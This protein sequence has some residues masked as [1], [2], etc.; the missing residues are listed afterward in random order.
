MS[1]IERF[2]QAM[3][4]AGLATDADIVGD[5]TL[6][7]FHVDGDRSGSKNGWLVLHLDGVAAGAFGSWK[8]GEQHTWCAKASS[9]LT[10]DERIEHRARIDA[11][12]QAR[13]DEERRVKVAAGEEARRQWKAAATDVGE[14]PYLARKNVQAHGLRA[15]A[16]DL[17]VPVHGSDGTLSSI[18]RIR[19]D[20]TKRFLPGGAVAG[21]Y[22]AI[23]R[24]TDRVVVC[25]GYATGA[26]IHEACGH[27]VAVAFNAGNLEPVARAIRAK[28]PGVAILIAADDDAATAQNPGRTK[29]TAAALAA[30][31]VVA[32]PDFGRSRPDAVSDFNDLAGL[33]GLAAVAAQ[34]DLAWMQTPQTHIDKV[35]L[36]RARDI[37][38]QRIE[39]LW[40]GFLAVSM[41]HILAGRAGTG[42][43]TI[44]ESFAAIR[45]AGGV[46]PDG[47]RAE[48]GA[49][50]IWSGEDQVAETL[51]PRLMAMGADLDLIYFIDAVDEAEGRRSFDPAK[52][53]EMLE[54][55][56]ARID[57]VKLLIVDPIVSAVR[58]S[59]GENG[60][61][62]RDLQP[63]VDLGARRKIAILGIT[64]FSKGTSGRDALERVTGSLAYGALA[65]IVLGTG[66]AA[67]E[68]EPN[69]LARIKSNIGP[70]GGGYEYTISFSEI[71]PGII[72]SRV[73]WG[74][75]LEGSANDIFATC[76]SDD[77]ATERDDAAWWLRTEL[78]D[79]PI[80]TKDLQRLARDAGHSWP[81][82]K[83][84]KKDLGV[85]SEKA[86]FQGGWRWMLPE[87]DQTVERDPLG[88][89]GTPKASPRKAFTEGDQGP[90]EYDPLR[91]QEDHNYPSVIPFG[92][93]RTAAVDEAPPETEADHDHGDEPLRSLFAEVINR[94]GRD[95]GD[96]LPA[97]MEYLADW[98]RDDLAELVSNP[99]L[100]DTVFTTNFCQ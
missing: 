52:D 44:A 14:H 36:L 88:G 19:P 80:A 100:A 94:H 12:K 49:V 62:R 99:V 43:T 64:H 69:T 53:M 47:S 15:D 71:E 85:I 78:A 66:K 3:A 18:Q 61:T 55:E 50:V 48:K 31:G 70:D 76:E 90:L 89:T 59:S 40:S 84:A 39:W 81:T 24:V 7:R 17:L 63:L 22:H 5:G 32:V 96:T 57:D 92:E 34:I 45:S 82:V 54:R 6:Q 42:K 68:G 13:R 29:A 28:Y 77:A 27:A 83:R 65:R 25:E 93:T 67:E 2:R 37:K 60:A 97:V 74:R 20:G 98:P 38:P 9:E 95:V 79:G 11:A 75:P 26:T 30:G 87:G 10:P 16:G 21:R 23:G 4:S 91:G 86:N 56:L 33:R 73:E 8:T 35:Q 72:G 41:V 46:W 1:S 58:A 51:V